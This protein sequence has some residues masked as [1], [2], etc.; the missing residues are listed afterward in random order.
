MEDILRPHGDTEKKN[1]FELQSLHIKNI[2][3]RCNKSADIQPDLLNKCND[4]YFI[5]LA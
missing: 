5:L 3:E 4:I 1:Q 2:I